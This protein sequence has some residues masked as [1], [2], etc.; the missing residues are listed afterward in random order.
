VI[1][2]FVLVDETDVDERR[3]GMEEEAID[4]KIEGVG[5]RVGRTIN[6]L[7]K[8]GKDRDIGEAIGWRRVGKDDET[9]S[10]ICFEM[11]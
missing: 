4:S 11:I 2:V 7:P 3:A 1:V 9:G 6:G 5:W 8:V 10:L